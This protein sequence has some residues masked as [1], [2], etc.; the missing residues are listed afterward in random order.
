MKIEIE[1][2]LELLLEI[3]YLNGTINEKQ[4]PEMINLNKFMNELSEEVKK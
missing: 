3:T 1:N 2:P 4:I